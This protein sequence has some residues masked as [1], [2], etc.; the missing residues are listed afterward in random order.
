MLELHKQSADC[1][2]RLKVLVEQSCEPLQRMAKVLGVGTASVIWCRIGD[3]RRYH[4]SDA[5]IK[6]MGLNLVE[7]SSG[8]YQSAVR[9]S[10]RGDSETRRWLYLSSLRWVQQ[11]PVKEWYQR[12]KLQSG[13][14]IPGEIHKRTGGK[15]VVAVMRKLMK[16][17]WYALVHD[18]P[19]DPKKL[20]FKEGSRRKDAAPGRPRRKKPKKVPRLSG[21]QGGFLRH[22]QKS[23][24]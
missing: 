5:W 19:F 9:I 2:K 13:K 14:K 12:K 11:S 3:P 23:T 6:A 22:G 15:A 24:K 8:E 4:C 1:K 7:Q 10:K 18:I 21:T 17:L 20:F 16:G